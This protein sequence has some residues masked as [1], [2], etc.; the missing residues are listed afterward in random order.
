MIL[1]RVLKYTICAQY[2]CRPFNYRLKETNIIIN[3]KIMSTD[4]GR[5]I[6]YG[7]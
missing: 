6:I 2:A 3:V 1:T 5:N 7:Q 4:I